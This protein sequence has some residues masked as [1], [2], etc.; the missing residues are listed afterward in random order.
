M[1][2][3]QASKVDGDEESLYG[4]DKKGLSPKF[5]Y[6]DGMQRFQSLEKMNKLLEV[7]NDSCPRSGCAVS[8]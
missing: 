1:Q 5:K 2:K 8:V 4:R 6:S 7:K 3:Q